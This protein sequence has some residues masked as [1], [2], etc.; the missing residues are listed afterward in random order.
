MWKVNFLDTVLGVVFLSSFMSD[1]LNLDFIQF[2]QCPIPLPQW[3]H[4]LD[5]LLH[6][7]AKTPA[8]SG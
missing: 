2:D 6:A 3:S 1:F 4:G 7:R 5:S 8:S